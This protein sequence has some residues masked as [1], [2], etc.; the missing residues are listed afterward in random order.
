MIFKV[1]QLNFCIWPGLLH[2]E[3]PECELEKDD[4]WMLVFDQI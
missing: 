2:Q 1:C 4:V 3:C